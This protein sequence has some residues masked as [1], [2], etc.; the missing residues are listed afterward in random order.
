ML[1]ET[2]C[3]ADLIEQI[4]TNLHDLGH[5]TWNWAK[6]HS[7]DCVQCFGLWDGLSERSATEQNWQHQPERTLAQAQEFEICHVNLRKIGCRLWNSDCNALIL[8]SVDMFVYSRPVKK[9]KAIKH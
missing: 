3:S 5:V 7:V 2:A 6:A 4:Y 8:G 1:C 9:R